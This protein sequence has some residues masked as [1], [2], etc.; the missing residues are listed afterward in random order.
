MAVQN[1]VQSIAGMGTDYLQY[2]A[3]DDLARAVAGQTNVLD[4]FYTHE[5]D[6]QRLNPDMED[7]KGTPEYSNAF[8]GYLKKM[9]NNTK[10]ERDGGY[11]SLYRRGGRKMLKKC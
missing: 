1:A 8:A 10:K 4:N 2:K 5:L 7:K 6:F 11:R 9:S 3:Q